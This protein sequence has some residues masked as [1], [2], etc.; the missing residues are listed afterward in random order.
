MKFEPI[1]LIPERV[2][3]IIDLGQKLS[4]YEIKASD[5]IP[6]PEVAL[7]IENAIIGTL[8]NILSIIGK[9]KSRKSF[10]IGMA[11]SASV[12]KNN[13]ISVLTNELPNTQ[14]NVLYFDT[15][16]GKYHVQKALKRICTI[17]GVPEPTNLNTYGL[18]E[19]GRAHV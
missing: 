18:R 8:G 17:T 7:R 16:Q 3:T 11:V 2:E 10:F 14:R 19:I 9:A 15:E 13:V 1:R 12:A 6:P 5:Q 4:Q